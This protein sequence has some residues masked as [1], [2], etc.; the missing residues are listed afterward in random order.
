M[1]KGLGKGLG[2][3]I[4][5]SLEESTEK[6]LLR[7]IDINLIEPN[8]GQPRKSFPQDKLEELAQS[9]KE[10]GV[11]QPIV[12]SEAGDSYTIVAGERRYRA[13]KIAG[14]QT[15]PCIVKTYTELEA[16]QIALIEN[17]QRHDLNPIEEALC[18]EQLQKYFFFSK[19]DIAKKVGKSKYAISLR[20]NLLSLDEEVQ[21][22]IM[23]EEITIGHGTKLVGL[24]IDHQLE[25]CEKIIKEG[26]TV[27]EV[28]ALIEKM[29][30]VTPPKPASVKPY[31]NVEID[32]KEYLQAKVKIKGKE[33]K[34]K[35]EIEYYS[36]EELLRI[37][38]M[39]RK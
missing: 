28:E 16:L 35:I 14:L 20:I 36:K 22:H 7:E 10:F 5:T 19:E 3:L 6:S 8:P 17:V 1:K 13:A 25:I 30:K 2:A 39:I 4:Q 24:P 29:Q 37:I 31:V 9:I 27:K 26:L 34:G 21:Q 32:L 33:E 38:E 15:M 11:I 12:L 18:Y 23:N